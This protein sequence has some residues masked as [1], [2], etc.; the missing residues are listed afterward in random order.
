[1]L[2]SYKPY[3][4]ATRSM[5]TFLVGKFCKGKK[6]ATAAHVETSHHIPSQGIYFRSPRI[7]AKFDFSTV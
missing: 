1:V 5:D 7:H 2:T 6:A 4:D 3:K